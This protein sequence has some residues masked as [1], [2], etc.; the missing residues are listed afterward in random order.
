M[1]C[2]ICFIPCFFSSSFH[3]ACRDEG[4]FFIKCEAIGLDLDD[5]WKFVKLLAPSLIHHI[6]EFLNFHFSHNTFW[7]DRKMGKIIP[8]PKISNPSDFLIF[9]IVEGLLLSNAC[10]V[11]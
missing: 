8:L 1:L 6:P 10:V 4:Q 3:K 2:N 9:Q 11:K 7:A 5:I